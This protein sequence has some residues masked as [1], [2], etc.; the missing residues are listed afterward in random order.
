MA[1]LMYFLESQDRE[2]LAELIREQGYNPVDVVI[3]DIRIIKEVPEGSYPVLGYFHADKNLLSIFDY[4]RLDTEDASN[5]EE[6]IDQLEVKEKRIYFPEPGNLGTDHEDVGRKIR[7]NDTDIYGLVVYSSPTMKNW[8][9]HVIY[10]HGDVIKGFRCDAR[11][12][13][14]TLHSFEGEEREKLIPIIDLPEPG[15]IKSYSPL[16]TEY[17]MWNKLLVEH[18]L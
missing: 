18:E 15:R 6:V 10:R 17:R 1:N 16:N 12:T 14:V 4:F 8:G 3:H 2:G 11:P 13:A 5:L 7:F 9:R